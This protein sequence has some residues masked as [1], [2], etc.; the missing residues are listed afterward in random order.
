MGFKD[1]VAGLADQ[2]TSP[3]SAPKTN[4]NLQTV[5][6]PNESMFLAKGTSFRQ[7]NLRKLGMGIHEFVLNPERANKTDPL[8]VMV[9]G[10]SGGSALHVGY[11]SK[12]SEA[13]KYIHQLGQLMMA[14]SEVALVTGEVLE[15]DSGLVVQLHMPN[16]ATVRR[17]IAEYDGTAER[18]EQPKVKSPEQVKASEELKARKQGFTNADLQC[19]AFS[20]AGAY[21]VEPMARDK[22]NLTN[23]IEG[24]S[25]FEIWQGVAYIVPE[26]S[27]DVGVHIDGV[28]IDHLTKESASLLSGRLTGATPVKC[29]VRRIV[30]RNG[31]RGH[32][33]LLTGNKPY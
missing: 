1:W 2:F 3:T 26:P 30:S 27:G 17:M 22:A 20:S 14:K 31:D 10:V 18:L 29:N 9:Q 23:F 21:V 6:L 28:C 33:N 24:I 15:G 7:E 19:R 8:A 4:F 5:L 11:L 25:E 32:I 13:Q 12:G 16:N